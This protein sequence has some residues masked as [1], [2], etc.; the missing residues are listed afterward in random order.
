MK[1]LSQQTMKKIIVKHIQKYMLAHGHL[2]ILKTL[3]KFGP[4]YGLKHMKL[5]MLKHIQKHI[6]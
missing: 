4:R 1:D 3:Q 6:V 2:L 5:I